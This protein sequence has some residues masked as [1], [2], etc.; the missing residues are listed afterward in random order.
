MI[1]ENAWD[2]AWPC[3]GS[4]S[5]RTPLS[6]TEA[7]TPSAPQC[8]TR[9]STV[10]VFRLCLLPLTPFSPLRLLSVSPSQLPP[11]QNS[12]PPPLQVSQSLPSD[13]VLGRASWPS[14]LLSSPGPSTPPLTYSGPNVESLKLACGRDWRLFKFRGCAV[15]LGDTSSNVLAL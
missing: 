1:F 3:A 12:V 15:S 9:I 11:L 10:L 5:L 6:S 2:S 4:S 14:P 8:S 13:S 7:L